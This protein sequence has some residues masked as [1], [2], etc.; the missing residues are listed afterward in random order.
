MKISIHSKSIIVTLQVIFFLFIIFPAAISLN[1][2]PLL[3]LFIILEVG[4]LLPSIFKKEMKYFYI[5]WQFEVFLLILLLIIFNPQE[6]F[7]R[8]QV[9]P[10]AIGAM[11]LFLLGV[12]VIVI[13]YLLRR[14]RAIKGILFTLSLSTTII[15]FLIVLFIVK[16]G[17]P[18]FQEN[19]PIGFITGT[20][21]QASYVSDTSDSLF[22][23]TTVKTYDFQMTADDNS[24]YVLPHTWR[25]VSFTVAN[26]GGKNDTIFFVTDPLSL[27]QSKVEPSTVTLHP[28]TST[29]VNV[30]LYLEQ[31]ETYS[32]E[33]KG[34]SQTSSVEK[35]IVFHLIGS[36][37]G[38]E[39]YPTKQYLKSEESSVGTQHLP[40]QITN[41]G[42]DTETYILTIDASDIFNPSIEGID[43]PWDFSNSTG[44]TTLGP[45]ESR[46][47]SVYPRILTLLE[48][49]HQV[50]ITA[51]S[52]TYPEITDKASI[53][54]TYRSMTLFTVDE[55]TKTIAPGGTINYTIFVKG[56]QGD[57]YSITIENITSEWTSQLLAN[58]SVLLSGDGTVDLTFPTNQTFELQL[59]IGCS[60]VTS[61]TSLE[62]TVHITKKELKPTYGILPFIVGTF[63][64]TGIAIMI[65]APLGLGCAIFLAEF[66]PKRLRYILRP[67]YE[68]L[69]GIPSVIYGLWGYLTF[70][71]FI[72]DH[73][74]PLITSSLGRYIGFFSATSNIGKDIL[75]ASIVLS[76]MIVPIIITLSEDAIRVVRRDLKEGSLALG[77][78]RWQTMRHVILPEAKSGVV[79]SIIL[80]T[81][82]AIGETMAVLMIMGASAQ[83]PT[84]IFDSGGT[85]TTVIAG[86]FGWSFTSE[87]TRHALFAVAIILFILIFILN[88]IIFSIQKK[89]NEKIK[90]D[91]PRLIQKLKLRYHRKHI[92]QEDNTSINIA[93][94][95]QIPNNQK[96]FTIIK[97]SS[98][99][100]NF[101]IVDSNKN[102]TVDP[103]DDEH[104]SS[105][106]RK[107]PL[108]LSTKKARRQERIM[109]YALVM[110]A[111]L[112]SVFFFFI[113]GDIIFRG[114]LALKPEFLFTREISGGL[115]GGF[116]NAIIGSLE[117]VAIAIAF[118]V[119]L[120]L[121][122]AIYVQEYTKKHSLVTKIILFASD[123]LASTPSIVFGAFG[124]MFFVL[125]LE[126]RF[127]M[128]AGGLTLGIM[129]IPL[130]LRSSIESIKAIPREY[131]EGALA[132]GATKWQTIRTVILPPALP[133][134]TSGTI[135]SI[136]RAIGETAAV[137]FTAG[138]AASIATSLLDATASMPNLIYLYYDVS[139]KWP[140]VG[141]K[142]YSA[143]FI[144]IIVVLI[145]NSSAKLFSYRASK[146]MKN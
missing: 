28:G 116:A 102:T 64:T 79:T 81:G 67:I 14:E 44:K 30:S 43:G 91:S 4:T 90:N 71:P 27:I 53:Q 88:V 36:E 40:L 6:T 1:V 106:F 49:I 134:I 114:G 29:T 131:E 48:G 23:T 143:A 15:V 120:A 17:Y 62:T 26:T 85:M 42:N 126:F 16:E 22:L 108:L 13:I 63:L 113:I 92:S 37:R 104:H 19:N 144:L 68:L 58:N 51:T 146:M 80:G 77:A 127:S 54:F 128:L 142:V 10:I 20:T 35:T 110:G 84:S 45:G 50:N 7:Q 135:I 57:T 24:L 11:T 98:G 93:A 121:G 109:R 130:L 111:I 65:A 78:T 41:I 107:N 87:L 47:L 59:V 25:N 95:L 66:C 2:P 21:W 8:D 61:N 99:E 9:S 3:L 72:A 101:E 5:A 97:D 133:G 117:L 119:P 31:Q 125:F 12:E 46:N 83:I 129:V 32:L 82:R 96:H 56:V 105:I 137:I 34:I 70:G 140:T 86:T 73:L 122:A 74:Y 39:L 123:T 52:N 132:L 100:K 75:T 115:E 124:F 112:V 141:A 94:N 136:G 33:I 76:I 55:V 18:A 139:S 138:Y 38:V 118:A 60:N 69:A 103:L 145:L 89:S